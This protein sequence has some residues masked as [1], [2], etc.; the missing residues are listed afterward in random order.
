[1]SLVG[2]FL[3]QAGDFESTTLS[4]TDRTKILPN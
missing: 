4:E 3:S 2:S 1:M